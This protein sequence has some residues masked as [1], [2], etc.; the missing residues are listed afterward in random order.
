MNIKEIFALD[1][2]FGSPPLMNKVPF[3][4]YLLVYRTSEIFQHYTKKHLGY[5]TDTLPLS[6]LL[7][8]PYQIWES[9][10]NL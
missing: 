5:L 6:Y 3:N 10:E 9:V 2:E 4:S 7:I 8:L 1:T